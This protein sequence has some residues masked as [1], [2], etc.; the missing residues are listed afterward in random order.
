MGGVV[1]RLSVIFCCSGCQPSLVASMLAFHPP[2]PSYKFVL[3]EETK[4][5]EVILLEEFECNVSSF[6]IKADLVSTATGTKIPAI[7]IKVADAKKTLLYSHGNATD[8]G[9]MFIFF[10]AVSRVLQC[11]VVAYDYTGY[12]ASEGG[13]TTDK[14]I[15]KDID[16]VYGWAVDYLALNA[17]EDLFVYGQSVG[18]GPSCYIASKREVAGLVL[19]SPILSGLRVI[20]PNRFLG[21]FDIF[22]NLDRI[23]EVSCPVYIIHGEVVSMYICICVCLYFILLNYR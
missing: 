3:N 4:E 19:H 1:C 15:Y 2:D 11:N 22:P 14:Q 21:C 6:A 12:G 18:S 9:A 5:Y 17:K 23:K 8:I 7:C 10:V 13:N 20:T 16:A